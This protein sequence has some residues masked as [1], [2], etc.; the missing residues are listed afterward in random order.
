MTIKDVLIS[1]GFVEGIDFLLEG[2]NLLAI[3]KTRTYQRL[4]ENTNLMEDI[5][6][7]YQENLPSIVECKAI[8]IES[9]DS[10]AVLA[11]YL[12][13]NEIIF[14]EEDSINIALILR[15][16]ISGWRCVNHPAPTCEDLYSLLNQ[17]KI[18]IASS[19]SNS[20]RIDSGKKARECCEKVLDL[21]AGYNLER[22]LTIQEITVLQSTFGNAEAALRAGRPTM[23]KQFISTI[24][25]DE[26]LVTSEMKSE[27]LKI[28]ENY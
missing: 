22:S 20:S 9:F 7:I 19:I 21:I 14:G 3:N 23:A 27:A 12:K 13:Q 26:V 16:D 24:S 11:E 1:K 2:E 5:V 15:N 6:E 4:N 10:S 18:S 8:I 28:L 17:A 25:P